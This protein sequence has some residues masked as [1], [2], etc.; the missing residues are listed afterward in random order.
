MLLLNKFW[1][2]LALAAGGAF[3]A[4]VP[5]L[6]RGQLA[7]LATSR[8]SAAGAVSITLTTA[9]LLLLS[10]GFLMGNT[11]NPFIYFRF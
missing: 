3:A 5:R 7:V 10:I 11:F 1:V 9:V 6:A 2:A 4:A 8:F